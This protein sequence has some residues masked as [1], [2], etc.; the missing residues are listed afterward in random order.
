MERMQA[1]VLF[2]HF[3]GGVSQAD[4]EILSSCLHIRSAGIMHSSM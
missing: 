3:G 2:I 1:F 4:F